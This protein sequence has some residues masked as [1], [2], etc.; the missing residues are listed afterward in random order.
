MGST[1]FAYTEIQ[2]YSV[3]RLYTVK[4]GK[5]ELL[6][7]HYVC[8]GLPTHSELCRHLW[9]CVVV[10]PYPSN[11]HIKPISNGTQVFYSDKY[12]GEVTH[13]KNWGDDYFARCEFG[14]NKYHATRMI[15]TL[16][17]ITMYEKWLRMEQEKAL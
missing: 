12:I 1:S 14:P 8:V 4:D 2:S 7:T 17:L 3:T 13:V 15:A 16:Y 10:N 11:V 6:A 5:H 9:G